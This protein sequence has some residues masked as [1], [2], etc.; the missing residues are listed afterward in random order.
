VLFANKARSGGGTV[1]TNK[2]SSSKRGE[3]AKLSRK[4]EAL[5][6]EVVDKGYS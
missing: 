1:I 4:V 6:K 5:Y 2:K 3:T